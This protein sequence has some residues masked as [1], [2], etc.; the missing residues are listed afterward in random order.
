MKRT[1]LRGFYTAA[2]LFTSAFTFTSCD[3]TEEISPD[4]H[5]AKVRGPYD[6]EGV[7]ILNEGNFGTPNGSISFLSDS[8]GHQVKNNIFSTANEQRPL[9]DVVQNMVLHDTLAYI[10]ANNSNKI[11]VVNVFTF[12]TIAVIEGLKQPRYFAALDGNKGYVTEWVAYGGNGRVSVIDLKTN[13]V[14]KTITVGEMPEQLLVVKDKLYVTNSGGNSISVINTTTDAL[15][16]TIPTPDGPSEMVLTKDQHIW[17]LSAGKVV[18]KDDWS[19]I[20]YTKTTPGSLSKLNTATS[21]IDATF[22]FPGNQSIPKNLTINGTGDKLYFNY[23]DKTFVQPVNAGVLSNTVI[24]NRGFYGMEADPET[25]NIY[26]SDNNNFSGDGTVFI[27]S[28]EGVKLKEFKAA[29][30]PNGFVFN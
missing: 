20:D 14:L 24:I 11:E 30:G 21:A 1:L 18:Y 26:G 25:G 22:T 19:G 7:F 10:V 4:I 15:A 2:L 29:I 12:K 17:V 9:G 5:N 13:A 8:T 6:Q 28:S 3:E 23:E 27:F 16:G